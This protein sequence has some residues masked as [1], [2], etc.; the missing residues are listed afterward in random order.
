MKIGVCTGTENIALAK[1]AGCDYIEL[2]FHGIAKQNHE[3]F[4]QTKQLLAQA[5]IACEAMNC[6]IPGEFE[7]ISPALDMNALKAYLNHGFARAKEL[8]AEVVV[9]GSSGA[10]KLPDKLSKQDGWMQLAPVLAL[11]GDCAKQHGVTVAIE[12]L[13]NAECNCVNTLKDGMEL[14]RL[15]GHSHVHLL[16]DMYH[17]GE[18]GE[19]ISD[20]ALLGN[21]FRHCHIA[22]PGNR[23][24][25]LP[26]DGYDYVPFF[27]TLRSIGY[28]G[29]LSIEGRSDQMQVE[30]RKSVAYLRELAA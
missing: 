20:I 4:V 13:R 27:A 12:P 10:R 8:G 15:I 11:A 1:A 23:G 6:F 22:R 28:A 18:N 5:G 3:E 24:Y 19:D 21:D 30:L 16:A 14:M 25:P 29:R 2:S 26:G 7:L 9:F 17:M